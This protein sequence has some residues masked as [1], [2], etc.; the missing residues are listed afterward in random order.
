MLIVL[1][2][3]LLNFLQEAPAAEVPDDILI[4]QGLSLT[5]VFNI[6]IGFL[7][8]LKIIPDGAIKKAIGYFLMAAG[9]LVGGIYA[10]S[11][12]ITDYVP[13][14]EYVAGGVLAGITATGTASTWKNGKEALALLKKPKS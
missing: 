3:M 13:L 12:G 7:R 10:I 6:I 4:W 14:L 11:Q 5:L 9:A 2:P 1:M 8:A